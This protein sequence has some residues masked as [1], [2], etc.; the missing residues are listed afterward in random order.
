MG[1]GPH[2]IDDNL[3]TR[4]GRFPSS[5]IS[6]GGAMDDLQTIL[7]II[8][9]ILGIVLVILKIFEAWIKV[10]DPVKNFLSNRFVWVVI[11]ILIL[12]GIYLFIPD[13]EVKVAFKT[14]P[15][16]YVTAMGSDYD[17]I[18]RAETTNRGDFEEFTLRCLGKDKISL[19]TW[20]DK[21]G[22]NRYVSAMGADR[23]WILM[24]ETNVLDD[25]ERFTLIDANTG[26]PLSCTK[27][28]QSLK[29]SG[30]IKIALGTYH[31][32]DG[33]QRLVTAMNEEWDWILRAETNAL[34]ASE[35]YTVILL[36]SQ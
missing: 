28:I 25:Y 11:V 5:M 22:I 21:D 12:L 3:I 34:F 1:S 35:I 10:S 7:A 6:Q 15:G 4:N 27:M 17:W 32:K 30:T 31:E 33:K 8:S 14:A 13:K 16:H 20:H 18:L 26:T 2:S 19:Q 23:D 9:T 36:S 29:S 24:A